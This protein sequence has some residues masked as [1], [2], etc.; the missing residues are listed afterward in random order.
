[1]YYNPELKELVSRIESCEVKDSCIKDVING[2]KIKVMRNNN[3]AK[4]IRKRELIKFVEEFQEEYSVDYNFFLDLPK[5]F[6]EVK[7]NKVIFDNN[8]AK[9]I[10]LIDC[11]SAQK[12]GQALTE[13]K[14]KTILMSSISH[15]LRT[16]VNAIL[17]TLKLVERFIPKESSKLL[18]MAKECCN[19]I[20]FHIND[21][22][23]TFIHINRITVNYMKLN[24]K[25]IKEELILSLLL[26]LVLI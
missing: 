14:C 7:V 6:I 25:S 9:I 21:L 24:Y 12:L 22:T 19:M 5:L 13:S 10:S 1:L 18:A 15:E 16:A 20:A 3:S 2:L 8:E 4:D 23:V 11:G 26:N 17:D